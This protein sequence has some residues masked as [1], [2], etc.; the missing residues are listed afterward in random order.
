MQVSIAKNTIFFRKKLA[1]VSNHASFSRNLKT[2]GKDV[3]GVP[4]PALRG[5]RNAETRVLKPP[6]RKR[7]KPFLRKG[8]LRERKRRTVF[9]T[10]SGTGIVEKKNGGIPG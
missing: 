1:F 5:F 3:S 10:P 9:Q 6:E 7:T 2:L 8:V 4:S